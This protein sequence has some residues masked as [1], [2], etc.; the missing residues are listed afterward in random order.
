MQ[1]K[2][3]KIL[4]EFEISQYK[5]WENQPVKYNHYQES[6]LFNGNPGSCVKTGNNDKEDVDVIGLQAC[7]PYDSYKKFT[8]TIFGYTPN[9]KYRFCPVL[10]QNSY[11]NAVH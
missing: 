6:N 5:H 2:K 3:K 11:Q 10:G 4:V 8:I 9:P 7:I 1:K